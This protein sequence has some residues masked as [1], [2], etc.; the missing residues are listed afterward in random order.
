MRTVVLLLA[1]AA[2]CAAADRGPGDGGRGPGNGTPAKD[3]VLAAMEDE[4]ARSRSVA[5]PGVDPPYFVEYAID[6]ARAFSVSATL[7]GVVSVRR[8]SYRLPEIRVRVGD[9]KFDNTNYVGSAFPFGGRYDVNRLPL[10]DLYPVLRRFLWLGTD[11]AY[12]SALE[13]YSRKR[14][15]L[16][17]LAATD[18]LDDFATARPAVVL[19]EFAPQPLDEEAWIARARQLSAVLARYPRLK[20]SGLELEAVEGTHRYMNTEGTRVR[21]PERIIFLRVRAMAQAKDGMHVRDAAVVHA[22]DFNGMP[23]MAVLEREIAAIGQ[24]ATALAGAPVGEVYSGPV[25][26]EGTAAPQLFAEILGGNLALTR[27]PVTEPGRPGA[28]PYSQ[29]EGRQGARVLPEWMDVVDDPTQTEYRGRRLFGSY[30]VDREGVAPQPLAIVEKGV[31]KN[32]LLTRRPVRG[33][34]GS[35]G[36]ARLP[37]SFGHNAAAPGNLFVS[38]SETVPAAQLKKKLLEICDARSKPYGVVVRKMDFP[39]S[40]SVEDARRLLTGTQGG[41]P[42]S[43]PLL[44]YRVYPDGREELVRGMRFRGLNA[45]SFKDILAA[46]DDPQ[47][48]DYLNNM[49]PFALMGVGSHVAETSVVAPSIL[50]DDLELHPLEDEH[51]ELPVVPPPS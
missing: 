26:F 1:A 41:Q 40:A 5:L 25:L 43:M 13:A 36:R 48:F 16:K 29:F 34:N 4:L 3:P 37:G 6:E 31:L 7:G 20:N 51:P 33:Y 32:F 12:K 30:Q 27:R 42:V 14:A 18:R 10:D 9:Y 15:A 46:G 22:P 50:I 47:V 24:N 49:A 23:A 2:L 11:T 28:F 8:Q 17:S 21:V 44:V 19:R 38:A 45:R 39:S 35:N